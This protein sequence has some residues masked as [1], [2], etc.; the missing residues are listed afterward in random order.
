MAEIYII[1][2]NHFDVNGPPRLER[3]LDKIKP[4]LILLEGNE[5]KV[6]TRKVYLNLV[7]KKLKARKA[8]DSLIEAILAKGN[9]LEFESDL[10]KKF[11]YYHDTPFIYFNDTVNNYSSNEVEIEARKY[12]NFISEKNIKARDIYHELKNVQKDCDR[13]WNLLKSVEGTFREEVF[14][15]DSSFSDNKDFVKAYCHERDIIMERVLRD[16]VSSCS[17]QK[18]ATINGF[19]HIVKDSIKRTLYSR[20]E[21]LNPIRIFLY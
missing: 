15:L 9:R 14:I 18:I 11:S 1:G 16:K 10:V 19:S 3:V 2:I 13:R 5:A 21:D 20:V 8:D 12:I 17:Y 4:N 6:K 7:V